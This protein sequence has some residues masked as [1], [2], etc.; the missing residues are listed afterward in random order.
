MCYTDDARPPSPPTN[1]GGIASE[2][3]LTLTA[4][5]GNRFMAYEVHDEWFAAI[6]AAMGSVAVVREPVMKYRVHG[7]NQIGVPDRG[8]VGE[9][10]HGL[11]AGS[12]RFKM[13]RDR[14]LALWR[15]LSRI[16]APQGALDVIHDRHAFDSQRLQYPAFPLSRIGPV[17]R[18]RATG[19][20]RWGS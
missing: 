15:A 12:V 2:G 10:V 9:F 19:V 20:T 6:G 8:P 1:G 17:S 18:L 4:S 14:T 3:P 11:R 5:D 13:H 16:G 7:L